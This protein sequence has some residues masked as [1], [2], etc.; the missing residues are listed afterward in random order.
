MRLKIC[1]LLFCSVPI[2]VFSMAEKSQSR[3]KPV[4][5]RRVALVLAALVGTMTVSA[6]GLLLMEGGAPGPGVPGMA[7]DSP[8]WASYLGGSPLQGAHWNYIIIYES[9][10]LSASAGSLAEGLIGG[11]PTP[12]RPKANFH[13]VID[14]A[15]S[16][17]GTVDG[18]LEVGTS[19]Q[20]QEHGAYAGWPDSRSHTFSPYNDAVGIC[21]SADLNRRPPSDVQVQNLIALVRQLQQRLNLPTDHV[22]FQWDPLLDPTAATR[23]RLAFSQ[24]IRSRLRS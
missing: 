12:A 24:A 3:K 11:S 18:G 4:S 9:G 19:W 21:L 2:Q 1:V 23:S 14:S 8:G 20:H 15:M 13:F 10:D 5:Q 16:G 6:G 7:V 17:S 22:L